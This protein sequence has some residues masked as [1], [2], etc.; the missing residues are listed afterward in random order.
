VDP[1][2]S[3]AFLQA[4]YISFFSD[5]TIWEG[6]V[7][8]LTKKSKASQADF[9]KNNQDRYS[10]IVEALNADEIELAYQLAQS[11]KS[12]A[13]SHNKILL[14]S[15]AADVERQL[16]N[17]ENL[18]TPQQM[19]ALE[20]ELDTVLAEFASMQCKPVRVKAAHAESAYEEFEQNFFED[21]EPMFEVDNSERWKFTNSLCS[22]SG[23]DD[24]D[25]QPDV[26]AIA[27][28]RGHA[29]C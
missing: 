17:G 24:W 3:L 23:G 2:Y 16:K 11:Q 21:F 10:E 20:T 26:V 12:D 27:G 5:I 19:A 8:T 4:F 1:L 14:K 6:K 9:V 28:F 29:F 15:A 25:Y 22:V 18:I 13:A 7:M